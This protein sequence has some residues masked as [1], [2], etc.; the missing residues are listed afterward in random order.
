MKRNLVRHIVVIFLVIVFLISACGQVISTPI[1]LTETTTQIPLQIDSN[2][3]ISEHVENLLGQMTLDAKI[4]QMTQV[5]KN[6]IKPG[7]IKKYFIGSILSGGGGYPPTNTA[8]AWAEMING[9]QKEALETRLGIPII[10]GVDAV[11]G[12][13]N[14]H[15][16]TIF[17]QEFGLGATRDVALVRQ[18][19][20]V[21]VEEMLA[22]SAQW[23]FAPVVA[24]PQD[25]RWG[26]T[27]EAYGEDPDLVSELGSAYIQGLQSPPEGYTPAAG[28]E[29]YLLATPKHFLGDGG[30]TFGTSIQVL[31]K[32][33]LLDQGDMRFDE[34]SIRTLNFTPQEPASPSVADR[35]EATWMDGYINRWFLDPLIGRGYPQDMVNSFG[36][37]MEIIKPGDMD[38]ISSP[39]DFLGVNY[40]MRNIARAGHVS[41]TDNDPRTVFYGDEITEMGWEVYPEGL[42][43]ILERL[44]FDYVFP[45]IYINENSAA[46]N[47]VVSP[48]GR[49]DGP[50]RLSYIKRHLEM[51]NKAI[52]V[53]VPVKG[54]FV[55]SLLDNFEWGFGYSKRFGIVYVNFQTQKRIPMA[56]SEWYQNV[57]HENTLEAVA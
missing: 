24:V 16:A 54:Y 34:A 29:L 13:G 14:L 2:P 19:G 42:Y 55:R 5:E 17:P 15:G 50:T 8:E 52:H 45:A 43:N 20:Q 26:R 53:G 11:H 9:F 23:N 47:D 18:I 39:I 35:K 40:Y 12:H 51:V 21:T 30:T 31:Y 28:Q 27:Y 48:D 37:A 4:G 10:Y 33:Y 7:D 36:N 57:I 56:S 6:S 22:T 25:I 46:F 32:P 3:T 38:I 41:E 49:D 44:H 1:P